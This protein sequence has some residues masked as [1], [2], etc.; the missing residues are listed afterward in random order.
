M[1]RVLV[2]RRVSQGGWPPMLLQGIVQV[3]GRGFTLESWGAFDV[4]GG[5][6]QPIAHKLNGSEERQCW[7]WLK[8]EAREVLFAPRVL[9]CEDGIDEGR[10]DRLMVGR[11]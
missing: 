11:P 2:E 1:R 8:E 9:E 6:R 5:E 3:R 7:D 10:W 4:S